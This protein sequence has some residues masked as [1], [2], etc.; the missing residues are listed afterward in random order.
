MASMPGTLL[1]V[2][3]ERLNINILVDLFQNDF[4]ILVAKN[5]LQA[6]AR[7][8]GTPRPDLILLDVIMPE[9]DGFEVCCRLKDDPVTREIPVIFITALNAEEDQVRGF[10]L[11]AVDFITKPFLPRVVKS[12][13][14]THLALRTALRTVQEQNVDLEAA[15]RLRD[16][17]ERITHHDLKTP[18]NAVINLPDLL[19]E[20]LDLDP[21]HGEALDMI[22]AA[23]YTMLEMINN[24]LNTFR[25][26]QG[27]YSFSPVPVDL[28]PLCRRLVG[29][30]QPMADAKGLPVPL[31]LNGE[32]AGATS[33]FVVQGEELLCYSMLA[34]LLK[35][36]MEASPEGEP[37][38]LVLTDVE[39]GK[40]IG[41][42]N[43]GEVPEEIR[44]VFFDKYVTHGKEGGSGLGTYSARLMAEAQRAA[45]RLEI[46]PEPM[47]SG[48]A[49]MVRFPD[50][51]PHEQ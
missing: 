11:G 45:I 33:A 29:E 40:E 10:D 39:G 34:N 23:G 37:V 44:A 32:P 51:E 35:N 1:I 31:F 9:M 21:E 47:G 2:D 41:I 27:V 22:Q 46:D 42:H 17:V 30:V 43:R 13:V 6:L 12:R 28:I 24:S 8:S 5:G 48:I 25:M 49:V 15:A 7:A 26:E 38:T 18:L 16:D 3:D 19:M 50:R 14:E 36:A 4:E 20:E